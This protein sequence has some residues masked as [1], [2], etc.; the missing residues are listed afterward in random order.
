MR[1]DK[2]MRVD[3]HEF[4]GTSHDPEVYI[5]WEKGVER[6]FEF[7]ETH[8]NQQYKI[9]KVKL[10]KL[11]AIWLEGVQRQKTREDRPKINTWEKL[12]KHLRRKYV[13]TNYKQKLY[14][15]WRNLRQG[16]KSVSEYIQERERLTV[17]CEVDELE[18]MK[19]GRFLC[20]LREDLREKIKVMQN[21]TY[22]GVCNSALILEKSARRRVAQPAHTFSKGKEISSYRQATKQL[23]ENRGIQQYRPSAS[24]STQ[25]HNRHTAPTVMHT[26]RQLTAKEREVNPK[27]VMCFKCHGHGHYKR[28]CPNAR[29]FTQKEWAEI[30]NR[31]GTRAVLVHIGGRE[32][33]KYPP[34]P[35]DEYE[36]S[37]K[38]NSYGYMERLEGSTTEESEE[39]GDIEHVY[40]EEELYNLLIRRNLHTV[41]QIGNKLCDLSI[42]GGSE[43][44]CV[45]KE[46]VKTLGLTTRPHPRPYKLRWLD[47]STGNAV[48]K[49]CLVSFS[50][51]TYHD[52][53]LCDVLAMDACHVFLGRPWQHDRKTIHNGFTNV[54]SL[55]HEG[56]KEC[57]RELRQVEELLARGYVRESLSPCAVPTLLVPKKDGLWRMCVDSRSVNNIT[58][59]YRFPMPRLDDMLNEL[60]G[61]CWFSKID[62][63]SGYH[64]IRM[65][66]GDEW[67][68]TFKTKYGLYEWLVMPFGLIGAPSTFMRLMNEVLRPFLGKFVVVYL[69]DIM[70]Y[71]VT[72]SEHHEHLRRLFEVLRKQQLYGKLEKCA[73]MIAEVNFLGFIIGKEGVKVDPLK[74]EPMMSPLIECTKKGTFEWPT[75]A[76]VAFEQIKELM[77]KAPVLRLPDFTKP[78]EVECDASGKEIGATWQVGRVPSILQFS[79]KYKA[80]K[81]NIV[82]D[83]LSR[84]YH[85]LAIL[86]AKILGLEMIKPLYLKDLDLKELC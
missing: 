26:E 12:R 36:G 37:F 52:Q 29:A 56:R 38:V 11:A 57:D 8:P 83:A 45:S 65:R 53:V 64:Q 13:P 59:K 21:L 62:L 82:A 49:Q 69:D 78:F 77:C 73:F 68:T 85:L 74:I 79:A 70:I 42:D 81:A 14:T 9:A 16:N 6:Y 46:L 34:T 10:T 20:G 35:E 7:K 60:A 3:L 86:E 71:S 58:V 25:Q 33:V 80:G 54:Y 19:I 50:I 32:E 40:P 75:E 55:R 61:A 17:L 84:R 5:E 27:N 44:N 51:G 66:E 28:N 48:S 67:K 39:E 22:E 47:D 63:R 23:S 24:H 76:Q 41:P 43:S 2:T 30:H 1:E 18:E 72:V 15:N 31:K 4:D